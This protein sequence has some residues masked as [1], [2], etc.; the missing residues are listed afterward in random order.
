M[1]DPKFLFQLES[2]YFNSEKIYL[3][4]KIVISIIKIGIWI[5]KWLYFNSK[6]IFDL[7][8]WYF[9]FL[10]N[11]LNLENVPW[12]RKLLFE[13]WIFL[14]DYEN[15]YFNIYIFEC[16]IDIWVLKILIWI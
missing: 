16:D 3:T 2:S 5:S 1:R 8:N 9:S 10:K 7:Q 12:F 6:K 4:L 15:C 11:Y 13:F 14:L